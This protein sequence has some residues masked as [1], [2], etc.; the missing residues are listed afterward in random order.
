MSIPSNGI[1][2]AVI[3]DLMPPYQLSADLLAST[4]ATLPPPSPDATQAERHAH[5]TRLIEEIVARQP[6]DADQARDAAQL[7][8]VRELAGTCAADAHAAGLT[9]EQRCRLARTAAELLR[10]ATSIQRTLARNQQ[11]PVPFYGTV[12][13]DAVDLAALDSI[14][15][16]N[17][18]Q[19]EAVQRPAPQRPAPQRPAPQREAPQRE[20]PQPT[21]AKTAPPARDPTPAARPAPEQLPNPPDA[22]PVTVATAH[23]KARMSP[24]APP[25]GA[26]QAQPDRAP[27][28]AIHPGRPIGA[29]G[30]WTITK[31]DEGP[32]WTREVLRHQSAGKP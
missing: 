13:Q 23:P 22:A 32:G 1:T 11:K 27:A 4:V 12:L 3:R 28:P 26:S 18:A 9:V 29:T 10:S 17:P 6:A 2:P 7:L 15:R 21:A 16:K 30:E 31:L 5:L 8:I 24:P 25:D 19:R 20:A 14:W